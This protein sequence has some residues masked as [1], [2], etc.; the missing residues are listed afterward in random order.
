MMNNRISAFRWLRKE[1]NLEFATYLLN[2]DAGARACAVLVY[3]NKI[4]IG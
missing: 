1:K 2:K 3:G 4:Y